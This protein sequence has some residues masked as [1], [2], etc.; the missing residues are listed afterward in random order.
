MD[1]SAIA[2]TIRQ[3]Y[4]TMIITIGVNSDA[5]KLSLADTQVLCL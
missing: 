2:Q 1:P 4:N 3:T 5:Y